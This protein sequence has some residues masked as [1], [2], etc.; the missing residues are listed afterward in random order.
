MAHEKEDSVT[1]SAAQR[2]IRTWQIASISRL[3]HRLRHC[4][5]AGMTTAE[6]A[7]GTL[8]A[9]TF[10]ALL[11]AVIRS[12]AIRSALTGLIT[13]ALGLGQ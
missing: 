10:A 13:T 8:A 2:T 9:C 12:P 7:I 5:E 3:M 11:I 6:Y 1:R 4:G